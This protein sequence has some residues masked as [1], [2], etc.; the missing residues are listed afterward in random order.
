MRMTTYQIAD[1]PR[2]QGLAHL[3]VNPVW[4]LFA[5]MFAGVWLSWP[6]FILNGFWMGSPSR[7]RELV[8]AL[9]GVVGSFALATVLLGA[10]GR[11]WI[12]ERWVG[13]SM[14]VFVVWKLFVSYRLFALQS[15]TFDLH[16]YYGGVARNGLIPVLLGAFARPHILPEPDSAVATFVHLV[17]R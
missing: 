13:T 6:W 14:A 10:V 5:F 8:T 7:N 15:R 4:C 1:E 2:P 16:Q 17:L 9:F 3:I 12:P 11:E